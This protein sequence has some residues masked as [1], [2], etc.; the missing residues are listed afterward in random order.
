MQKIQR[1]V[2]ALCMRLLDHP[3]AHSEYDSALI[4]GLAVLA[5]DQHGGWL[6][7][8]NY[9][10]KYSAIVKLARLLVVQSACLKVDSSIQ[11]R[12]NQGYSQE[13]AQAQAGGYVECIQSAMMRFM[14]LGQVEQPLPTPI[15]WIYHTRTYG[16]KVHYTTAV[17]GAVH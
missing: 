14:V 13:L 2:L 16:M 6:S 9:T 1:A 11:R 8:E 17:A 15:H 12:L 7:A 10:P 4:S 5:I 3:L